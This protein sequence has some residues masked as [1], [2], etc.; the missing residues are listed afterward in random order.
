MVML[1]SA[2]LLNPTACFAALGWAARSRLTRHPNLRTSTPA[3]NNPP[4]RVPPS[5]DTPQE[6][7]LILS[8]DPPRPCAMRIP[9]FV[10]HLGVNRGTDPPP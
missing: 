9:S 10:D 8:K 7:A 4:P 2:S 5:G 3:R 6:P 1:R